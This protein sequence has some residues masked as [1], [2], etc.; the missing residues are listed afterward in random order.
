MFPELDIQTTVT[1]LKVKHRNRPLPARV[2][3]SPFNPEEA[4]RQLAIE[5]LKS[6]AERRQAL[7][8]PRASGGPALAEGQYQQKGLE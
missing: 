3:L 4:W 7:Q 1:V 8:V 5:T 6:A 2:A